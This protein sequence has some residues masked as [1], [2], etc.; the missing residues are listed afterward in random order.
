MDIDSILEK[1]S[2]L[3]RV[4]QKQTSC[5]LN[6][7]NYVIAKTI[8]DFR[9][10]AFDPCLKLD[11]I[12]YY[13][14]T[15]VK[16]ALDDIASEIYKIE[17]VKENNS[18]S[19]VYKAIR[20]IL[21]ANAFK[22]PAFNA[23]DLIK[24]ILKAL[25]DLQNEY[26]FFSV[27]EGIKLEGLPIIDFGIIQI[28]RFDCQAEI[29]QKY[30]SENSNYSTGIKPFI[31]FN[32]ASQIIIKGAVFGDFDTAKEK[33]R[34]N[35]NVVICLLRLFACVFSEKAYN[36]KYISINLKFDRSLGVEHSLA[37]NTQTKVITYGWSSTEPPDITFNPEV[38]R[39]L[40]ENNF[41]D[42]LIEFLWKP[43]PTELEGTIVTAICWVGE[44]QNERDLDNAF[45]KYW[46]AIE[47]IFSISNDRITEN[48]SK[49]LVNVLIFGGYG[50]IKF[51]AKNEKIKAVKKLYRKRS[52][53]VHRGL[54]N[55]VTFE[56]LFQ[57]SDYAVWVVFSLLSIR[58]SGYTNL[59]SLWDEI[60][61]LH[62]LNRNKLDLIIS[63]ARSR[64]RKY[65]RKISDFF[66]STP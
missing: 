51:E 4:L 14:N 21:N 48:I 45:I 18:L 59:Q 30:S 46:T 2:K 36:R 38:L 41:F 58:R 43:Q 27:I 42:D 64:V 9:A 6:R 49:G 61:R 65:I 28:Q 24:S 50:V 26:H 54:R 3:I 52:K 53:V 22:N 34:H 31:E 57:I 12:D 20:N 62:N 35:R 10:F 8:E 29:E 23:V 16:K 39:Q 5:I 40:K 17:Q 11:G 37:V 56:E 1:E 47:T 7:D 19:E 55:Q 44:A 33:F 13:F 15:S 63:S 32:F 25:F 60:E 66:K